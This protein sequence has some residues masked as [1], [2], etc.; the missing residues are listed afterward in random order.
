M[1]ND[2]NIY[3][4]ATNLGGVRSSLDGGEDPIIYRKLTIAD[5]G[6]LNWLPISAGAGSSADDFTDDDFSEALVTINNGNSFAYINPGP[7]TWFAG[8]EKIRIF[9]SQILLKMLY[10]RSYNIANLTQIVHFILFYSIYI[11]IYTQISFWP[12]IR[13][14]I[15]MQ[16]TSVSLDS[17]GISCFRRARIKA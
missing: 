6:A 14:V 15:C 4:F 1:T 16:H 9:P 2:G 17:L 12:P 10:I 7:L 3:I 5:N 11:Y 13:T 8:R